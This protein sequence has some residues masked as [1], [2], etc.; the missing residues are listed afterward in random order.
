MKQKTGNLILEVERIQ[1]IRRKCK[2]FME[3]CGQCGQE[4]NFVSLTE[5]ASLFGVQPDNLF[6]FIHIT[7]CHFTENSNGEILL[8]I[9]SLLATVRARQNNN[10]LKMIK[11]I[12]N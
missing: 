5:A 9:N 7:S 3:F 11:A 2:T 8:C 12:Q 1:L 4:I 6:K 10:S